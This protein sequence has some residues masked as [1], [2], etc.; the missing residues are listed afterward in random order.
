MPQPTTDDIELR[1]CCKEGTVQAMLAQL[2]GTWKAVA[3]SV[4]KA[5]ALLGN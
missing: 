2:V 4:S 3:Y 5:A 1:I